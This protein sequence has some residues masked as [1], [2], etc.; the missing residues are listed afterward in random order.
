MNCFHFLT[1][2]HNV[3]C[4]GF[5]WLFWQITTNCGIKQ[6]E[7]MLLCFWRLESKVK[8]LLL[9]EALGRFHSLLP[10]PVVMPIPDATFSSISKLPSLLCFSPNSLWPSLVRTHVIAFRAHPDNPEKSLPLKLL[11][12]V[13]CLATHGSIHRFQKFDVAV[14]WGA[15]FLPTTAVVNI[16]IKSLHRRVF[17]S[18]HR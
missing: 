18:L 16:H 12:L 11:N 17:I 6:Q 13:K 5:L 4:I 15:M 9:L 7:C 14:F 3:A 10:P 8:V 2:A 1:I